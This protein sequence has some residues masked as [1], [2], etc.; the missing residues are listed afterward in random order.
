M[1]WQS[2]DTRSGPHAVIGEPG[3]GSIWETWL[4]RLTGTDWQA[5]TGAKFDLNTNA[6]RPDGWTSGDA[7]GFP[8]FPALVRYD[9][10]ER[11]MV[12]HAC[13]LVVKRTRYR[14]YIYPATHYAAP[15]TNTS[16]NLP[17][18]GQRL[19]LKANFAIPAN[20]TKEEKAVLLAL[21]K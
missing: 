17:S 10:A 13:R 12:E 9:E 18:M 19:R 16:V 3:S 20:W 4:T 5:A 6:L 15:S 1:Q 21:K 7:A 2:N 8:M 14:N 11:G